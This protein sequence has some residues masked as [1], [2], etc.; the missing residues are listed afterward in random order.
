MA[1]APDCLGSCV[2]QIGQLRGLLFELFPHKSREEGHRGRGNLPCN[3]ITASEDSEVSD[4]FWLALSRLGGFSRWLI[5]CTDLCCPEILHAFPCQ[6]P[7]WHAEP[8]SWDL[9]TKRTG[10]TWENQ[11]R[12]RL[13][14][15]SL[16]L[17][18][19]EQLQ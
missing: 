1:C 18:D 3:N 10:K 6:G 4:Q 5:S 9:L 11:G 15:C 13:P 2:L 7:N 16:P 12:L 14:T 17:Y 8:L 19:Y